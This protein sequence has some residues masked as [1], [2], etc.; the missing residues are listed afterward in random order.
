MLI[1]IMV[2]K[3]TRNRISKVYP[4][5]I[6]TISFEGGYLEYGYDL[7]H[8]NYNCAKMRFKLGQPVYDNISISLVFCKEV[9]KNFPG[10][11][12]EFDNFDVVKTQ[13]SY[14]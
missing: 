12:Y 6:N 2:Y 14:Y 13:M 7:R 4:I 9:S 11:I 1:T 8:I 3:L 10:L 5:Q